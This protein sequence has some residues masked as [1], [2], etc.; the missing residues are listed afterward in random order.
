MCAQ[1]YMYF[2]IKYVQANVHLKVMTKQQQVSVFLTDP[3]NVT[4]MCTDLLV[5]MYL[6]AAFD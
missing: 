5:K 4:F 3:L 2:S 6:C 1:V